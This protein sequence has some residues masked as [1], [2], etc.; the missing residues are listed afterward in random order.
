M[1]GRRLAG[2]AFC[3]SLLLSLS[4]A[5]KPSKP[6][7]PEAF[8][9]AATGW[10][11]T[12][13]AGYNSA[14]GMRGAWRPS[15]RSSRPGAPLARNAMIVV[16]SLFSEEACRPA[17]AGKPLP[18]DKISKSMVRGRPAYGYHCRGD[19]LYLGEAW[20]LGDYATV[21]IKDDAC[22]VMALLAGSG[23]ARRQAY[24]A[25]GAMRGTL[26]PIQAPAAK[27]PQ[28][29]ETADQAMPLLR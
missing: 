9:I 22:V 25:F 12:P 3:L 23:E 5:G 16:Y 19:I 15:K 11:I 6:Q 10:K 26:A 4:S 27:D 14:E 17:C 18:A 2:P 7:A 29:D 1:S 28:P 20:Q 24:S 21:K 13:P 8:E